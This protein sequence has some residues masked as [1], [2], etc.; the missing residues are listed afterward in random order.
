MFSHDQPIGVVG[1]YRDPTPPG[2]MIVP[3]V[4][5]LAHFTVTEVPWSAAI[6]VSGIAL[7][8]ALARA[9]IR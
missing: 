5:E 9:W 3:T 4:P 8:L 6:L 1:F 7:G 2:I